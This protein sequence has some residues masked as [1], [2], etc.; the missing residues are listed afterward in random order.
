VQPLAEGACS[1]I[2][3]RHPPGWIRSNKLPNVCGLVLIR[4]TGTNMIIDVRGS[5]MTQFAQ[6]LSQFAGRTVEDKTGVAGMFNFHLEFA[7]ALRMPGHGLP[8]DH[9]RDEAAAANANNPLPPPETGPNLLVSL[10]EQIGLKL[11]SEK[12][13][14]SVLIIDH[15]EK[16]TAN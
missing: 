8:G 4:S 11:S 6:R 3:L 7:P 14:V 9:E 5:T 1:P 15:V 12:G 16:P 10:Q 13:P 2:D